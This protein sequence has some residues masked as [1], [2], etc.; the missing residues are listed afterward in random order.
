MVEV[1][2]DFELIRER[3]EKLLKID[4]AQRNEDNLFELMRLTSQ[5]KIFETISSP[6][7][8]SIL[9]SS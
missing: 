4:S 3:F 8:V 5:F 1:N 2:K 7:S 9:A 6:S